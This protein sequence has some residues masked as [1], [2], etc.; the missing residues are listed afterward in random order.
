M[1]FKCCVIFLFTLAYAEANDKANAAKVD[2]SSQD[3]SV[4]S[5]WK[6]ENNK[7]KDGL[8][9]KTEDNGNI[10]NTSKSLIIQSPAKHSKKMPLDI[11]MIALIVLGAMIL[12]EGAVRLNK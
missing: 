4:S 2:Q 3:T 7:P 10:T 6:P 8:P 9:S 1:K 11:W 12:V 5:Q